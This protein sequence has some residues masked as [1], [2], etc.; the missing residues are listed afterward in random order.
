MPSVFVSNDSAHCSMVVA[1]GDNAASD[2]IR[3]FLM[4]QQQP[5]QLIEQVISIVDSVGFK[6][7]LGG[8]ARALSPEAAVV[9][10]ADR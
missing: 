5:E 8:Q 7:E 6:D 10:D 9:Q 3:G 2:A 4:S 1:E